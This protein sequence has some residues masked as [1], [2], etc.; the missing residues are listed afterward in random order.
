MLFSFVKGI[1]PESS[2]LNSFFTDYNPIII[3]SPFS[4]K[5]MFGGSFI[6]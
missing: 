2:N 4:S 1:I 3:L 5:V 6:L